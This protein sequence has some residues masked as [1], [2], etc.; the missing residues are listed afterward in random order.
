MRRRAKPRF[1]F[2]G[3]GSHAPV[4][5]VAVLRNGSQAEIRQAIGSLGAFIRSGASLGAAE[6][7]WLGAALEAIGR[8][9]KPHVALGLNTKRGNY[10]EKLAR[11]SAADD[12]KAQGI[13]PRELTFQVAGRYEYGPRELRPDPDE[14]AGESLKK[15]LS[16]KR[17]RK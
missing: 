2:D 6:A 5:A 9:E 1:L 14:A 11:K 3:T 16:S 13:K 7:E 17:L 4:P 15:A 8:G 12:L 10:R